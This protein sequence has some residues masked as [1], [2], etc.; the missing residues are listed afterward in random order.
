[1]LP[2]GPMRHQ[3]AVGDQHARR[4]GV[5]AENTHRLARLHE[6]GLVAAERRQRADDGVIALPI[7]R[8]AADT[9]IHHE[10]F[11][12]FGNL[13]VQIVHQHAQWRFGLPGPRRQRGAACGAHQA[14]VATEIVHWLL[15]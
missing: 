7:A 5:G 1:M 15:P 8:R 13:G 9:A 14:G 3:V 12:L 2:I 11:G 10:F 6:Q 4:I